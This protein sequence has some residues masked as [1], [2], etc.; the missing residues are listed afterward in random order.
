M[1][2]EFVNVDRISPML[3]SPDLRDWVPSNHIVHFILD[4][5]D[6]VPMNAAKVNVR[7]TGNDQYPP[8]IMLGLLIF[9]LH[10]RP[11]QFAGT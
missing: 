1:S 8:Q 5:L 3:L 9:G 7:G 11:I 2:R 10:H 4:A 6:A